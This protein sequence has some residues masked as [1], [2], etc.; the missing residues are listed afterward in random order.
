MIETDAVRVQLAREVAAL[1]EELR[2]AKA[3]L[4]WQKLIIKAASRFCGLVR[5]QRTDFRRFIT[6][7]QSE[8]LGELQEAL[9]RGP[10]RRYME[11]QP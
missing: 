11:V 10:E 2:A 1:T 3:E 8:A 7:E 6:R 9:L 5:D 4:A